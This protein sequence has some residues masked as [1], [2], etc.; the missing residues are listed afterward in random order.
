MNH[1]DGRLEDLCTF[2][3]HMALGI[4]KDLEGSKMNP[5]A[6]EACR[7]ILFLRWLM[8][9]FPGAFHDRNRSNLYLSY[10]GE[11]RN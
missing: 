6:L 4:P 7:L 8:F 9:A 2:T 11:V 3:T 1:S 5:L 10:A